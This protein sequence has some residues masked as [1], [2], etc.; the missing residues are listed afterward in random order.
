VTAGDHPDN[1]PGNQRQ[2]RPRRFPYGGIAPPPIG[3]DRLSHQGCSTP[4]A[5]VLP[6]LKAAEPGPHVAYEL[7]SRGHITKST[8]ARNTRCLT[9]LPLESL[10]IGA[11]HRR[12]GC[13]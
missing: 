2:S 11:H 9:R 3:S 12:P 13:S 4:D 6:R 5:Q 10:F 7:P 8:K 1:P